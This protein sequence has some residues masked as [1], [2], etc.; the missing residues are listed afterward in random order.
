MTARAQII[1]EEWQLEALR[2]AAEREGTSISGLVREIVS[3]YLARD[4][5]GDESARGVEDI[6]GLIDD[7]EVGGKDH[8]HALYGETKA[9]DPG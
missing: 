5:S 3:D 8:D 4:E 9:R 6:A 2:S 7:R 1:L